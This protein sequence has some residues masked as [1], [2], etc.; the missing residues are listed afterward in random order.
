[1]RIAGHNPVGDSHSALS[2]DA[3]RLANSAAPQVAG[4]FQAPAS[5]PTLE[6]ILTWRDGRLASY[7]KPR[8]VT[9]LTALPRNALGNVL[10]EDLRSPRSPA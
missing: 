2:F 9:V 1:M 5:P 7:K 8:H 10:K 3:E 6:E 4:A